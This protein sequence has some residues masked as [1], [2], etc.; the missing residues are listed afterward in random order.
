MQLFFSLSRSY[1]LFTWPSWYFSLCSALLVSE[2]PWIT[3][4]ASA[5]LL[6]ELSVAL[7]LVLLQPLIIQLLLIYASVLSCQVKFACIL[8]LSR[9][10]HLIS[11]AWIWTAIVTTT[12]VTT[13]PILTG[14]TDRIGWVT[15]HT[16]TT[17]G[18][19]K[20]WLWKSSFVPPCF[21]SSHTRILKPSQAWGFFFFLS[22]ILW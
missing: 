14:C 1:S 22:P 4:Q 16:C 21:M 20:W 10:F 11:A 12:T 15:P 18:I 8:Q 5:S 7:L 6:R 2:A 3:I 17:W 13:C 9:H 19:H